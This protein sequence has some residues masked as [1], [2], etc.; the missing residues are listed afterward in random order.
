M[1]VY[2]IAYDLRNEAN[3]NGYDRLYKELGQL[4][5][6]RAEDSVWFV[7]GSSHQLYERLKQYT[8]QNDF[9]MVS[10]ITQNHSGWVLHEAAQWLQRQALRA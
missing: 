1:T 5:A 6:V 2:V 7:N 10:E 3:N 8:D 9:L 4:G